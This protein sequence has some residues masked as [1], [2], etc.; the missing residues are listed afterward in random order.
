MTNI[1]RII[2]DAVTK[3]RCAIQHA[4]ES[5]LTT[6]AGMNGKYAT[7]ERLIKPYFSI[8]SEN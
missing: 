7:A 3:F 8:F 4:A 5:E 1:V 6:T 2:L